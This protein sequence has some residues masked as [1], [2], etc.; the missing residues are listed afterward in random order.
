[1]ADAEEKRVLQQ[2]N[3]MRQR[4]AET[5]RKIEE[6][7]NESTEHEMVI[8][9]LTPMNS[10]RKCFR[11]IGDVLVERTVG[12]TLPAVKQHKEKLT[13]IMKAYADG[14]KEQEK[15]LSEFQVVVHASVYLGSHS[16]IP[17]RNSA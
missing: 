11:L 6:L 12:E 8:K 17:T 1:M 13:E 7:T 16:S 5:V 10:D 2:F 4:L 15:A 14:M 9:A 3:A